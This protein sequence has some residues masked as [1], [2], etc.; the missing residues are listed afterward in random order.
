MK[1]IWQLLIGIFD[2]ASEYILLAS[3]AMIILGF[4]F[5]ETDTVLGKGKG[6]THMK[7]IGGFFV[8]LSIILS[9][10]VAVRYLALSNI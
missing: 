3:G 4:V 7:D 6:E 9:L 2:S 8:K 1:G 10:S 5:L